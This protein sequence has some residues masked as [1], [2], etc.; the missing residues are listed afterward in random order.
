MGKHK[1]STTVTI[2]IP[3]WA[4]AW[5]EKRAAE[6]GLPLRRMMADNVLTG[7]HLAGGRDPEV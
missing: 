2:R 5:L 3:L 6:K 7:I 4:L 1:N